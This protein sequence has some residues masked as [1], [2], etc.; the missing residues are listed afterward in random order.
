MRQWKFIILTYIILH[1][2]EKAFKFKNINNLHNDDDDYTSTTATTTI[3][4]NTACLVFGFPA[5][6]SQNKY[7][8]D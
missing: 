5:F 6:S 2:E 1:S 4:N 7:M 3:N 8:R